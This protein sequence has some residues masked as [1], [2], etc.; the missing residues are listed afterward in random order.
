MASNPTG[1][2]PD[3]HRA[4]DQVSASGDALH[5]RYDHHPDHHRVTFTAGALLKGLAATWA[6]LVLAA[7]VFLGGTA[8]GGAGNGLEGWLTLATGFAWICLIALVACAV[9]GFPLGLVLGVLL[10]P[11]RSQLVHV[12][13]FF[14]AG[15]A[16]AAL[17]ATVF[18]LDIRDSLPLLALGAAS[19][20]VGRA[21][22][23]RDV[24]V[25][26]PA[27]DGSAARP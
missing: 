16:A 15:A 11:V 8:V 22:V 19:A 4:G 3:P 1:N 6:C 24:H 26:N 17:C 13:V 27:Q 10:R 7:L 2:H 23:W 20:A 21:A 12:T 25:H 5:R 18:G 14:L 9:F